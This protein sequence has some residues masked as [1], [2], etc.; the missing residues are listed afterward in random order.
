MAQNALYVLPFTYASHCPTF[1]NNLG[2]IIL[3]PSTADGSVSQLDGPRWYWS[4]DS[5]TIVADTNYW[6][7]VLA[8]PTTSL[9]QSAEIRG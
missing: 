9:S 3:E 1:L 2:C 6:S 5:R 7:V 4:K 8:R